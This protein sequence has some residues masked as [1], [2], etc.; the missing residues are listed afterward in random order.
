MHD[1]VLNIVK[2]MT[3]SIHYTV[4]KKLNIIG[5]MGIRYYLLFGLGDDGSQGVLDIIDMHSTVSSA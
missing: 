1:F 5:T 2:N 4:L 3:L